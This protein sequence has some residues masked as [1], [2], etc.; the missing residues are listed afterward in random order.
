MKG[1]VTILLLRR[2][3]LPAEEMEALGQKFPG[4]DIRLERIDPP[5]CIAHARMCENYPGAF[6]Y[7]PGERPLPSLAMKWGVRHITF[8]PGEGLQ[9]LVEI[10]RP[11]FKPLVP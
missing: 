11:V 1:E 9:E 5:D 8:V 6:V 4:A 2:D 7:L 3:S 10:P